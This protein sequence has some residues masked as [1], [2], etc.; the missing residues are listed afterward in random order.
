MVIEKMIES[1]ANL[2]LSDSKKMQTM[3]TNEGFTPLVLAL[4]TITGPTSSSIQEGTTIVPAIRGFDALILPKTTSGISR[5]SD[6]KALEA[7]LPSPVV[8]NLKMFSIVPN[9]Q[10]QKSIII[11]MSKPFLYKDNHPI[12]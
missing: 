4:P 9:L 10:T 1:L 7:I 5:V 6:S 2:K 12:P 3:P 11:C 8:I